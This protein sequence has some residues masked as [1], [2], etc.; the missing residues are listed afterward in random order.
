MIVAF[1]N[2]FKIGEIIEPPKYA[3]VTVKKKFKLVNINQDELILLLTN[4][5]QKIDRKRIR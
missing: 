3:H 5:I 4:T 2:D 1:T